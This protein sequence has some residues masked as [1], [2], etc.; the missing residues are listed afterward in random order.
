M[1]FTS[2]DKLHTIEI[3]I[4]GDIAEL[5]IITC[6]YESYKTFLLLLKKVIEYMTSKNIKHIKQR[7]LESDISL[8][9]NSTID[10]YIYNNNQSHVRTVL[11]STPIVHIAEEIYNALGLE[12]V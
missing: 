1:L 6:H 9:N 7:I 4:F 10:T 2:I 11:I 12:R 8:F 5:S 3:T